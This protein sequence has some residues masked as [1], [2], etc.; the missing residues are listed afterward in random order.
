MSRLAYSGSYHANIGPH[1]FPMIKFRRIRD[2]LL[3]GG[4]AMERDFLDPGEVTPED[5]LRV[6]TPEYWDK[7]VSG[8][9]PPDEALL[10]MPYTPELARAFRAMAQGSIRAAGAALDHGFGANIG[11]GFHHACPDHGEGFCMLNDVAIA[12]RAMQAQGRMK[13]AVVVD[14]DVHQGNGT[15]VVFR[16]DDTVFTFS[17][18]QENNYPTPKA[19]GDLDVGLADGTGGA[20]YLDRLGDHLPKILD[21]H[22][23]DLLAYVAGTDPYVEDQLGGLR[24]TMDDILARDR[25]VMEEAS[26]RSIPVFATLAGGYARRLED[27][28]KMHAGMVALG[29]QMWPARS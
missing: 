27:T 25:L 5:A 9:G 22:R 4:A 14:T 16:G 20:E 7:V 15:A 6:H 12:I 1:V 26:R 10:E 23:P 3:Q 11:G 17:I 2:A 19:V 29:L 13:R 18:H 21:R 24:L 8:F 28:V